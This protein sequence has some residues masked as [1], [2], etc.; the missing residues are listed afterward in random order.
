M[1]LVM[2]HVP[3]EAEGA[4]QGAAG[5]RRFLCLYKGWLTW[6]T[7]ARQS[8]QQEP[9]HNTE[10]GCCG[11]VAAGVRES[12]LPVVKLRWLSD[13]WFWDAPQPDWKRGTKGGNTTAVHHLEIKRLVIQQLNPG[14]S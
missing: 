2:T 14:I 4:G 13:P 12:R 7:Q 8:P 11:I 9:L 5:Q 10:R 3:L 1:S 6:S